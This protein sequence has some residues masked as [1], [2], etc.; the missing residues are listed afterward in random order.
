MSLK[1][2][3]DSR[4]PRNQQFTPARERHPTL[5]LRKL[6]LKTTQLQ[7]GSVWDFVNSDDIE[8]QF[9]KWAT[10]QDQ[11]AG[12][13]QFYVAQM[14]QKSGHLAQAVKAY[15]AVAVHFPTTI[16][17]TFWKTPCYP[18]A[19]ASLD[20]VARG[21]RVN[22]LNWGYVWKARAARLVENRF[23]DDVHNDADS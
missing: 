11:P 13:R 21:S 8:A 17:L 3:P 5:R 7:D 9:Y 19:K 6:W 16:G 14:L 1:T 15:Y 18:A 22:I 12:L 23:D 2:A 10:N 20:M 4:P